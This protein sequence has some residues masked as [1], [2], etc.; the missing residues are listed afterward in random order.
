MP[1]E[2][3]LGSG[4]AIPYRICRA[5]Q[6]GESA[7]L[8]QWLQEGGDINARLS[9]GER[10]LTF[11]AYG[12]QSEVT[13]L[14]LARGADAAA[15]DLLN[16]TPLHRAAF[17]GHTDVARQLLDAGAVIDAASV[18]CSG[19]SGRTPLMQAAVHGHIDTV[20]LLLGRGASLNVS[21]EMGSTVDAIATQFPSGLHGANSRDG[22][23]AIQTND[24]AERRRKLE[25]AALLD[26]VRAAGGWRRYSLFPR[27]RL[28]FLRVLCEQGRAAPPKT[29]DLDALQAR[30]LAA[31]SLA[32]AQSAAR[33]FAPAPP[34][35]LARLFPVHLLQ[36]EDPRRTRSRPVQPEVPRDV[37]WHILSFWSHEPV[38]TRRTDDDFDDFYSCSC[39]PDSG[40]EEEYP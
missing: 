16:L 1:N 33:A 27:T 3:D 28:L 13:R 31:S 15:G 8:E 20:R 18:D 10:L 37:F 7:L 34:E 4:E 5:A 24:L 14:L 21:D 11:A 6:R 32:E 23:I 17:R 39:G 26:D 19:I 9:D 22:D 12:G 36:E 38:L 29:F 30:V 25:V 40:L 2:S 35:I